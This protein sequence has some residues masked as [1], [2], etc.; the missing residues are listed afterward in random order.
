MLEGLLEF[1]L[2]AFGELFLE[3]LGVCVVRGCEVL[4]D[5]LHVFWG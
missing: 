1:A 5:A 4:R 2:K 3:L